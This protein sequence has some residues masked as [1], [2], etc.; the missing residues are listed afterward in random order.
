[1]TSKWTDAKNEFAYSTAA[2][3][4]EL[5]SSFLKHLRL[6]AFIFAKI[7]R[8]GSTLTTYT[9]PNIANLHIE[10]NCSPMPIIPNEYWQH[11]SFYY[12][13]IKKNDVDYVKLLKATNRQYKFD[14]PLYC[15]AQYP[16]HIEVAAFS[17][18]LHDDSATNRY[19]NNINEIKLFINYFKQASAELFNQR[20][21]QHVYL[22]KHLFPR[23][24]EYQVFKAAAAHYNEFVKR[25][26]MKQLF[27]KDRNKKL[28]E[29]EMECLYYLSR[30]FSYKSIANQLL[31][32]YRTVE[33]HIINAKFKLNLF[34][35]TELINELALLMD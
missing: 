30:G 19:L 28:T 20:H 14:N 23:I 1:M 32:S 31:I 27:N 4:N 13:P 12:L 7:Y 6:S 18:F 25:L 34:T 26:I 8:N 22:P 9:E 29:R 17:S 16:N 33:S 15:V 35:K 5:S 24:P 21:D 10:L 2:Q 3:V 11:P